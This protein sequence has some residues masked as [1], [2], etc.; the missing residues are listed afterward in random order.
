MWPLPEDSTGFLGPQT[1]V[2][3]AGSAFVGQLC[4]FNTECLKVKKN[5]LSVSDKLVIGV[6]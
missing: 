3:Q 2:L 6:T 5:K 1:L 4:G